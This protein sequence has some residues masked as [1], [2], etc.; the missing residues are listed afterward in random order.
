MMTTRATDSRKTMKTTKLIFLLLLS[1][2]PA[3]AQ[4]TAI[5]ATITDSDAQ[6]WNNGSVTAT[7][8]P[9]PNFSG[10]YQ[11]QGAPFVPQTYVATM[12]GGG[13]FTVTLPD[14]TYISPA[15]TQWKFVICANTSAKCST[16]TTPI[17]G[18]TVNLS[19]FFS[20]QVTA[21]RFPANGSG[22]V[23][24]AWGY[25][26][27]EVSV[28]PI[29]GGTYW[30]VSTPCLR[31]WSGSGWSCLGASTGTC[32]PPGSLSGAVLYDLTGGMCGDTAMTYAPTGTLTGPTF[33]LFRDNSGFIGG[34]ADMSSSTWT[35][36]IHGISTT[37][38][39]FFAIQSSQN[40]L[41][42]MEVNGVSFRSTWL[43]GSLTIVDQAHPADPGTYAHSYITLPQTNGF[44][45][46]VASHYGH[47]WVDSNTLLLNCLTDTSTNCM[48]S[49]GTVTQVT[50]PTIPSW[51]TASVATNTTT[52]AISVTP[53]TGQTTGQVIGT[54]NGATTFAPCALGPGDV[55]P[56]LQTFEE[57]DLGSPVSLPLTGT[58][59][60]TVI[61]LAS[62]LVMPSSGCPCRIEGSYTANWESGGVTLVS[63]YM[64]TS[65]GTNVYDFGGDQGQE[66]N[67]IQPASNGRSARSKGTYANGAT[68]TGKLFMEAI[69]TAA[70]V[71]VSPKTVGPNTNLQMSVVTSN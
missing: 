42:T 50:F 62:P 19:S 34:S 21:P 56:T 7:F 29:Q 45:G 40:D 13:T 52:P 63:S 65:D 51:L 18:P 26:D 37:S 64:E 4:T 59:L 6:T 12:N 49:S 55:P 44:N 39:P 58:T 43:D 54:C 53:T 5:T 10:Q 35:F 67:S 20:S 33:S 48:P 15:G 1:A 32:S 22:G 14:N 47:L 46:A 9:N 27:G 16:V 69:Q 71:D 60:V 66:A 23:T 61:T 2:L 3:L 11:Y 17:Q 70:T 57:T 28:A 25:A 24:G 8:V 30:N 68:V 38:Y 36:G 41:P 31:I